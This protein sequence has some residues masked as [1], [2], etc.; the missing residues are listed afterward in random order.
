MK[1]R[2]GYEYAELVAMQKEHLA[3]WHSLLRPAIFSEVKDYV[4]ATNHETFS[5]EQKHRVYRGQDLVEIIRT[6]PN[7]SPAYEPKP[8]ESAAELI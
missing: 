4:L 7:L 6:W 8:V 2:A 5:S 1:D 3:L